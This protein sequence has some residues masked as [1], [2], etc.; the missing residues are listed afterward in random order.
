MY[1]HPPHGHALRKGRVSLP[2]Q[3]YLLTSVTR[4]RLPVFADFRCVRLLVRTLQQADQ[5]GRSQTLAFVV[6]PDHLHWLLQLGSCSLALLMNQVKA[7]S[8]CAVNA[9][10]QCKG[11]AVW[12]KGFHDHALRHEEDLAAVARYIVANPLR[13]GLVQ[14]IGDYPHWDAVW[15]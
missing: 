6:M 12:Q 5:L 4:E 1:L 10:C 15:L 3:A 14:R 8:A 13:A 11:R 9:Y 7:Q 2:G